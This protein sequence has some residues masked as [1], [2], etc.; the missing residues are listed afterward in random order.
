MGHIK[1]GALGDA[2]V[3]I[4]S[5]GDYLAIGN[6]LS[7]IYECLIANRIENARLA[8]LRDTLL[9]RLM[10]GELFVAD[11]DGRMV[12]APTGDIGGRMVSTPT[13][14]AALDGRQDADPTGEETPDGRMVSAPTGESGIVGADIIRPQTDVAA[15]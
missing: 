12:S 15:K 14:G 3:L 7:P 9:P 4:P 13:D 2:E 5:H 10:S 11:V 6:L 1:R 8:A